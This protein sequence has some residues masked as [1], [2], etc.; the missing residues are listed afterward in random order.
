MKRT[1]KDLFRDCMSKGGRLWKGKVLAPF[2]RAPRY[3]L[4]FENCLY[5]YGFESFCLLYGNSC[6]SPQECDK[7]FLKVVFEKCVSV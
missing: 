4:I 2:P 1:E 5:A 7:A 6:I 3:L